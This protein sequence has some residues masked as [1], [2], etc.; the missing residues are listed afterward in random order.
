MQKRDILNLFG[1]DDR[2]IFFTGATGH[3]GSALSQGLAG[4]GGRLLVNG[5]SEPKVQELTARIREQGGSAQPMVLDITCEEDVRRA[6]ADV[7]RDFG[8]LD[9][10]V[11]NAY[12]GRTGDITDVTIE[13]FQESYR[14]GVTAA[15]SII[16]EARPLLRRTAQTCG[17]TVSVINI[18]SMYGVV[19]PDFRVYK[20]P[21]DFNPPHYGAMKSALLQLTRYLACRLGSEGIRVN[22]ISPGPFPASQ[23]QA[24]NPEFCRR[25]SERVPLGRIGK[26][27]ELLGALCFL[28]SD[29]SSYVTGSNVVVDGGWTT[30]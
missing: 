14:V 19:S 16:Q 27:D 17:Q 18:A 8:R 7:D 29:A 30:W 13:D 22:A 28:A 23:V 3:L 12:A 6:F 24:D 11:N 2:V 1:L 9:V 25:L 15:F 26:P 10:I 5:R 20:S 4:M 21:A